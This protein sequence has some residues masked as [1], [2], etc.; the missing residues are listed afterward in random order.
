M[1]LLAATISFLVGPKRKI[2]KILEKFKSFKKIQKNFRKML[3][4]QNYSKKF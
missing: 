3:K 2:K 1:G 4:L